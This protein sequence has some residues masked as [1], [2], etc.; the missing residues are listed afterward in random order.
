MKLCIS[1]TNSV[2]VSSPALSQEIKENLILIK[3]SLTPS[4][5]YDATVVLLDDFLKAININRLL[6]Y[7]KDVKY[8]RRI[9]LLNLMSMLMNC[10]PL[11]SISSKVILNYHSGQKVV[12]ILNL[13]LSHGD[14]S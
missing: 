9:A 3:K 11:K 5:S 14:F 8:G 7:Y 10:R 13:I 1:K 12:T 6:T 2:E 4:N